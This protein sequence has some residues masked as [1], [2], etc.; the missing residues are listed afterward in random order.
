MPPLGMNVCIDLSRH[1]GRSALKFGFTFNEPAPA[2][3]ASAMSQGGTG[4]S[5]GQQIKLGV[6]AGT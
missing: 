3:A 5:A 6:R 1:E 2:M 4:S